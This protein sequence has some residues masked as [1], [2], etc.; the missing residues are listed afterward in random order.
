M[1]TA[2]EKRIVVCMKSE[3]PTAENLAYVVIDNHGCH[4]RP[5]TADETAAYW[6]GQ[7]HPVFLE[8]RNA[9]FTHPVRLTSIESIT[10]DTGWGMWFGGA[11]F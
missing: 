6:A 3:T 4:I 9:A 11:G 1:R 10:Q 2:I 8:T 5:A 7:G